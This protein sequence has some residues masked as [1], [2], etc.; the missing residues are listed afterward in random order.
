MC[1]FPPLLLSACSFFC[2]TCI[3]IY[4]LFSHLDAQNIDW[5]DTSRTFVK[6]KMNDKLSFSAPRYFYIKIELVLVN[7][8]CSQSG[9]L[10]SCM[11]YFCLKI[12]RADI[13]PQVTWAVNL[14]IADGLFDI[15]Q[16]LEWIQYVWVDMLTSGNCVK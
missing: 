1:S 14:M 13:R 10:V 15:S 9:H 8:S 5:P 2:D 3:H 6:S 16:V 11:T 7:D 4:S 12:T